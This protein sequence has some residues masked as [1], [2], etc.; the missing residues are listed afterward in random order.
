MKI[1]IILTTNTRSKVYI[2]K[3]LKNKINLD[4]I[5]FLNNKKDDQKF[6]EKIINESK[7][8]GFDISKSVNEILNENKTNFKEFNFSDIN[9]PKLVNYLK[10]SNTDYFIFSGGG[11]LKSKILEAGPK[12]IHCHPGIVPEYRGSTCFYY[13]I[14]NENNC[15]VTCFIMDAN[16]DTGD[17]I[18]QKKFPCPTNKFVDEVYDPHIRAETLIEVLKKNMLE[19]K[20]FKK[21]N[22]GKGETYFI[23]HPVLKHIAILQCTKNILND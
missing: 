1:G 20:K 2:T 5:I 15:G 8:N 23:I 7:K 12:F 4:E 22:T 21:Q 17:I 6:D 10:K 16:L 14:I 18:F 13:S 11:I 19:K 9:N 3:L